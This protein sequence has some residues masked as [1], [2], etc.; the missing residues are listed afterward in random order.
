MVVLAQVVV[1]EGDDNVYVACSRHG[2]VKETTM[3]A[4]MTW[5]GKKFS[6][7]GNLTFSPINVVARFKVLC[8]KMSE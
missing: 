3:V 7:H 4:S 2:H 6:H 5:M 8:C 1:D